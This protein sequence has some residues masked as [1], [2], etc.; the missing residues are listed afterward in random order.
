MVNRRGQT[1]WLVVLALLSGEAA[2]Q[3]TPATGW[4]EIGIMPGDVVHLQIW[5]EPELSFEQTVPGD[6][7]VIFHKLGPYDVR[8]LD[9]EELRRTLV[10]EY[11]RYLVDAEQR[12]RVDVL[13]KVQISGAVRNPSIYTLHPT[14]SLSD[15]LAMAGGPLAEGRVD[16]MELRREGE[17]VRVLLLSDRAPLADAPIRSGDQLH[18]PQRSAASR[19]LGVIASVLTSIFVV[20]ISVLAR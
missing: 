17:L 9:A 10:R 15:A 7:M 3:T 20:T 4:I 8:G 11:S 16:R 5:R 13:R 12:I 1:V 19:N 6:G 2:A 18:V 14:L